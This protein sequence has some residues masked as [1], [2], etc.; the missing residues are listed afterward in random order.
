MNKNDYLDYESIS[1]YNK[2]T[3]PNGVRIIT[4][5]IP[6]FQS[7]SL[8]IWV[9]SGSR[10]EPPQLNGI[11]H[12]IEHMLFKGTDSRS[13]I[14]IA[15]EIDA[16][17][18]ALNAFTSK[19]FTSFYCHVLNEN[20]VL[21]ADLLTDIFLNSSFPE[22]EIEREKLVI[23]R[24]ICQIEDNA[25]DLAHELLGIRFWRNDP[26]G[27]PILGEV[28]TVEALNRE[29][30]LAFKAE[31]YVPGEIVV[32]AAGR[33]KHDEFVQLIAHRMGS[34]PASDFHPRVEKART[35]P[36]V[37]VINRDMEQVHLCVALE[38]PGALDPDR[39]AA[40]LMNTALGGGM[41]SRLFQEVREKRGLAYNVYSFLST[42]SD[43]G[44]IGVYA[45]CDPE[46]TEELMKVVA[47]ETL[48]LAD[49]LTDEDLSCARSQMRGNVILAMESTEARMSRLAKNEFHF[50]RHVS[51]VEI[52]A[53]FDRVTKAHLV[54]ATRRFIAPEKLTVVAVGPLDEY[55]NFAP[56]FAGKEVC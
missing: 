26:L 55:E 14:T 36:S 10:F 12:F 27:Q 32:S 37:H 9:R 30:L 33:L 6:Y 18:G 39:H 16:V 8:G 40:Y 48:G 2:T 25:E 23:C 41:S 31:N 7:V 38:G 51:P 29:R 20:L 44:I 21:A 53:G 19:E 46:R 17:G 5:E 54:E 13:A 52:L 11:C 1:V 47:T 15:K 22:D 42:F 45:G 28:H 50:G 35:D 34:I 49:S 4:E 3:L 43:T 56:L 24:E